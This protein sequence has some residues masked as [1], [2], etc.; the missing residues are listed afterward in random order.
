MVVTQGSVP[1]VKRA[2]YGV[3]LPAASRLIEVG[4][5]LDFKK[6]QPLSS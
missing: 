3:P 6:R 4:E 5:L 1:P 2:E